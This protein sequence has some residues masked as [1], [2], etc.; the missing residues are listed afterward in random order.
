MQSKREG[1]GAPLSLSPALDCEAVCEAQAREA[2]ALVLSHTVTVTLGSA[3]CYSN[4]FVSFFQAL[5]GEGIRFV[6]HTHTWR[7]GHTH[8]CACVSTLA[9]GS[10]RE[11][12]KLIDR[13]I[14]FQRLSRS[15]RETPVSCK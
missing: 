11:R 7:R 14:S 13:E 8:A 15:H 4:L 2:K 1:T 5:L 12:D 6:E 3:L 9:N 10:E